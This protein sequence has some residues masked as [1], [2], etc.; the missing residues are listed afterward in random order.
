MEES[1][2]RKIEQGETALGIEF[3][4][5]R[6]KAVLIDS[7]HS[8]IA[9]GAHQWENRLENGV[10]TYSGQDIIEGLQSAYHSLKQDVQTC[11][12]VTL[13]R[14]GCIGISAMMH[15]YLPL[16]KDGKQLTAFRT[17]R[18]RMTETAAAR[19]TELFKFH[20]PQ[21]WTIAHL[22]QAILNGE[23]H[24]PQIDFLTTLEG[25]VH[26][27]LSGSRV[28]GVG[29]GAGIMPIDATTND[30]DQQM[31][32]SFE[33]LIAS[34]HF[35]WKLRQILP[36][37]LNA[38]E[39]A[40]TLTESGAHLL[41]PDGDLLTGISLCPPEGDAGT[42]MVATKSV[43]P[44]TGNVSAGTSIFSMVVLEKPLKKVYPEIDI[45]AT[46]T[47]H[48]VAMVHCSNCSSDLNA[49]VELIKEALDALGLPCDMNKLYTTLFTSAMQGDKDCGGLVNI[50]YF[51]G[52]NITGLDEGRPLFVRTPEAKLS[53][54][55]FGRALILSAMSTL[56]IGMKL[57]DKEQ[58]QIDTLIGHGG[59]FKTPKVAQSLLASALNRPVAVL[60]N[61]GEGG[62][63]GMA[64]LAAYHIW[65]KD[66]ESLENYLDQSV[67][68]HIR[69]TTELPQ[70]EDHK[71]FETYLERFQ[72]ALE[73]ERKAVQQLS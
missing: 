35:P 25:Y 51:S 27:L 61:A 59:I 30:Y 13:R 44:R 14:V 60:E 11:Y 41:D 28:I 16:G 23:E 46:P 63:W 29:E 38:G 17:W 19:L 48:P 67:F 32:E 66:G 21:R 64:L 3:G 52:E 2:A 47:G 53:F 24:V 40:G 37:V 9:S 58:V 5:T 20:I 45:V 7:T 26:W 8:P 33:E 22:Y 71:A 72:S 36:R 42:G 62:A 6:I 34:Y 55:N 69:Q 15:G 56:K 31:V 43:Q 50:G 70:S 65:R 54:A 1:I 68:A 12:G 73:I 4:S 57:L 10:W 49:W 39:N 18:N